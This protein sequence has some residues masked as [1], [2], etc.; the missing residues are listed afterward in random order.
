MSTLTYC[1]T[2]AEGKYNEERLGHE[3]PHQ[4]GLGLTF[5]GSP[6][7]DFNGRWVLQQAITLAE[8]YEDDRDDDIAIVEPLLTRPEVRQYFVEVTDVEQAALLR[9][10]DDAQ[11]Y[12]VVNSYANRVS[13]GEEEDVLLGQLA[14][15][16]LIK[17]IG[18]CL[19]L[20]MVTMP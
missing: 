10:L 14:D 11:D 5:A 12:W 3:G 8:G 17:V 15:A 9:L 18:D 13:E 19:D 4:V 7:P 16:G 1:F 20:K 6:S 2:L